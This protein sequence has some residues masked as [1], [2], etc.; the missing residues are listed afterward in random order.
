MRWNEPIIGQPILEVTIPQV[1][2]YQAMDSPL[3]NGMEAMWE[4][5]KITSTG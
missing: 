3:E 5:M 1:K 2:V 4:V